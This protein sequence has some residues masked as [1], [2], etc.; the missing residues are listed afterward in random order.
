MEEYIRAS[1]DSKDP[2]TKAELEHG[3]RRQVG[4]G[5]GND[6]RIR[7]DRGSGYSKDVSGEKCNQFRLLKES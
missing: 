3:G 1:Q 5:K 6:R 2:R 7:V 4:V